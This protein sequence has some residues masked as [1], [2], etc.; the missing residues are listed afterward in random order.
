MTTPLWYW[1]QNAWNHVSIYDDQN[2][3]VST[4]TVDEV[5]TEDQDE[6]FLVTR[7]VS[8]ATF[9]VYSVNKVLTNAKS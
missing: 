5:E 6:D 2:R 4:L 9:I 7:M 8:D 1:E 3:L